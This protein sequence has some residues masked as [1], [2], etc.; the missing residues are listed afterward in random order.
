MQIGRELNGCAGSILGKVKKIGE[1]AAI[2]VG[3][4]RQIW[5]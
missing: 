4:S 5:M 1:D 2:E 3:L